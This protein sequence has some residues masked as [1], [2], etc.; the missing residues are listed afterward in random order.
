MD[1]STDSEDDEYR[2]DYGSETETIFSES[3]AEP[4]SGTRPIWL[5]CAG[6]IVW[7]A[8]RYG[9]NL[10]ERES[11]RRKMNDVI[12]FLRVNLSVDVTPLILEEFF[13]Q[14]SLCQLEM[15]TNKK[16]DESESNSEG[17][18]EKTQKDTKKKKL[19][20]WLNH[21]DKAGIMIDGDV[22]PLDTFILKQ[23]GAS[24]TMPEA[25]EFIWLTK[26]MERHGCSTLAWK[27]VKEWLPKE[28]N[29]FCAELNKVA[30]TEFNYRE[31]TMQRKRLPLWKEWFK[32]AE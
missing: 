29:E 22:Y 8:E 21:L 7:S 1:D 28:M 18:P 26:A 2:E 4:I 30:A 13:L 3:D 23:G 10:I 9:F 24:V 5:W 17:K 32:G 16:N 20:S 25:L 27:R 14:E 31:S 6:R 15:S 19:G 12:A 11:M